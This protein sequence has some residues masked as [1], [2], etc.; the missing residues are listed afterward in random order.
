MEKLQQM[1]V[2][3]ARVFH[4][5]HGLFGVPVGECSQLPQSGF[6]TRNGVESGRL[7]D[8]DLAIKDSPIECRFANVNADVVVNVHKSV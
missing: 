1:S 8:K 5:K 7:P 6:D 4:T 3:N 2:L